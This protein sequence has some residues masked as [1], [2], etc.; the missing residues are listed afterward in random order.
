MRAAGVADRQQKLLE[1]FNKDI[2][3]PPF[4][5]NCFSTTA[6]KNKLVP[7]QNDGWRDWFDPKV[8]EKVCVP[9]F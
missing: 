6:K 3:H 8:P 2:R 5:P 9:A 4:R 7:S 1:K